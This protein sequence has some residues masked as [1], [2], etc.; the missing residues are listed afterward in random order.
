ML[1]FTPEEALSSTERQ[2]I[3]NVLKLLAK[4]SVKGG[5]SNLEG[6]DT[7]FLIKATTAFANILPKDEA[8]IAEYITNLTA[9]MLVNMTSSELRKMLS[10]YDQL[11]IHAFSMEANTMITDAMMNKLFDSNISS[12]DAW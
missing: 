11:P 6:I 5:L 4:G 9:P 1:S 7:Y 8:A 12:N 2:G 10:A 3:I